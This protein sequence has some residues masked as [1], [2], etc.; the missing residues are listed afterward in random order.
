[1]TTLAREI[2]STEKLPYN[3]SEQPRRLKNPGHV[4]GKWGG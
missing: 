3:N 4:L 1:M 2:Q